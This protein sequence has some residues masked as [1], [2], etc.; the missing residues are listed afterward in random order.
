MWRCNE[1]SGEIMVTVTET[2]RCFYEM[3][4]WNKGEIDRSI[5]YDS[6]SD[7]QQGIGCSYCHKEIKVL[8]DEAY[9]TE[10]N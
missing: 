8:E 5:P 1:C 9:W 2:E 6:T 4:K 3:D 7:S 10:E